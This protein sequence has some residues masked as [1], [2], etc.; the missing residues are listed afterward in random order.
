MTS[1]DLRAAPRARRRHNKER[2]DRGRSLFL[3]RAVV[4][5]VD[6]RRII[7]ILLE[8][9]GVLLRRACRIVEFLTDTQWTPAFDDAA[10]RHSGPDQRHPPD[11]LVALCVAVPLGLII[12][13]YLSANS[14]RRRCARWSS[15]SSNSSAPCPTVVFG[16]F[17]LMSSRRSCRRSDPD[18]CPASTCSPPASSWGS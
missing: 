9:L 18:L 4:S 5:V 16:Y 13:I 10:L 17:A 2:S 8:E 12:A 11:H 3:A 6:H 7:F 1:T 14:R 15:R